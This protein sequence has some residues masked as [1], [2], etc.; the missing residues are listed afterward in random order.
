MKH[1]GAIL[2]DALRWLWRDYP[3]P[4]A[5][6]QHES[7]RQFATLVIDPAHD[8]EAV[9]HGHK[10]TEGPAVDSHGNVFLPTFRTTG[11]IKSQA[12]AQ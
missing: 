9:S 2:P 5:K 1:G 11:S 8:W 6:S 3:K 10:F 12:T 4:I 7:D